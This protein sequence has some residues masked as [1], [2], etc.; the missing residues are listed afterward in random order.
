M[1]LIHFKVW[2][3]SL[4]TFWGNR[5]RFIYFQGFLPDSVDVHR[6]GPPQS[7]VWGGG[8]RVCVTRSGS[9]RLLAIVQQWSGFSLNT[10]RSV[11][12]LKGRVHV[13]HQSF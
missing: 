2:L 5:M 13:I 7:L 8:L 9:V 12:T 4:N 1:T 10:A 11:Q 6:L 3:Q